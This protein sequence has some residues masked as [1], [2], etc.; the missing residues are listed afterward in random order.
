MERRQAAY[1]LSLFRCSTEV[2]EL[3]CPGGILSYSVL[4]RLRMGSGS[5]VLLPLQM[6]EF[7]VC[8]FE[9]GKK[10]AQNVLPLQMG[11]SVPYLVD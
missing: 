3:Y 2:L 5:D 11:L 6:L 9:A 10:V 7:S 4:V 8:T 1:S